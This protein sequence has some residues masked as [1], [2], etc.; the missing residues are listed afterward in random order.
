MI[1]QEEMYFD[2]APLG[3]V[4]LYYERMQARRREAQRNAFERYL[5]TKRRAIQDG[6]A[7]LATWPAHLH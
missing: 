4:V 1:A 6:F 7:E 5:P 3:H 2:N